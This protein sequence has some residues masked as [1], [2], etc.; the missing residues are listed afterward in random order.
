MKHLQ[1]LIQEVSLD[2][3][4]AKLV[5]WLLSIFT[6]SEDDSTATANTFS[7]TLA[8]IDKKYPAQLDTGIEQTIKVRTKGAQSK[9][10]WCG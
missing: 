2:Q 6:H 3:Q 7:E 8:M 9:R 1:T 10:G 5:F 4:A